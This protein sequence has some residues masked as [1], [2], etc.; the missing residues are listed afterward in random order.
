MLHL[1]MQ[2]LPK[3][4]VLAQASLP[5]VMV[6]G[7]QAEKWSLKHVKFLQS[8]LSEKRRAVKFVGHLAIHRFS[9]ERALGDG[10]LSSFS[11]W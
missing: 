1:L 3:L 4:T 8:L 9:C 5:Q 6:A 2:L 11:Q 7:S 10:K